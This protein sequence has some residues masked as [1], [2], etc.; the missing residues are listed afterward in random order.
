MPLLADDLLVQPVHQV[1]GE[2][3]LD[4]EVGQAPVDVA[5]GF[6]AGIVLRVQ[7]DFGT[8][9]AEECDPCIFTGK[10]R[11]AFVGVA[12]DVPATFDDSVNGNPGTSG[13]RF[14]TLYLGP[15]LPVTRATVFIC[16]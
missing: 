3:G 13:M 2:G 7:S 16:S 4:L 5:R 8:F 10:T 6:H 14:F 12:G 11:P 9:G 15:I 1:F